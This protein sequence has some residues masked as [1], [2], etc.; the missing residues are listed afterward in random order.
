MTRLLSILSLILFVLLA[1][2]AWSDEGISPEV[3]D[4]LEHRNVLLSL[5]FDADSNELTEDS[6]E[7]LDRVS[8]DLKSLLNANKIVR[9]EGYA[10]PSGPE[11]YNLLLSMRRAMVVQEYLLA[12]YGL[13]LDLFFNGF[14][15]A[16]P[17]ARKLVQLAFYEDT[18]GLAIADVDAVI[19]R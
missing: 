10:A 15:S 9:I 1:A 2:Q 13:D 17:P 8:A 18:L 19:T 7:S 4:F 6:K 11:D 3:V 14:G 16:R 12:R 5:N